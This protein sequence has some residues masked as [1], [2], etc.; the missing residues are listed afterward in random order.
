MLKLVV[1]VVLLFGVVACGP[2][3]DEARSLGEGEFISIHLPKGTY[4]LEMTS[5]GEGATVRWLGGSCAGR[6]RETNAHTETCTLD[7]AGQLLITNPITFGMG[8]SAGLKVVIYE[9]FG[10]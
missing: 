7:Q 1:F 8:S 4:R 9:L 3:Y 10:R 5:T 2:I 6:P